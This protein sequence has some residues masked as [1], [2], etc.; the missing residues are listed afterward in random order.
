VLT[1]RNDAV[2][3]ELI[4]AEVEDLLAASR[5]QLKEARNGSWAIGAYDT[6]TLL[7]ALAVH[8]EAPR[9][10]VAEHLLEVVRD[11]SASR[12]WQLGALAGLRAY[13]RDGTLPEEVGT[14]LLSWPARAGVAQLG[15]ETKDDTRIL[16]AVL[17]VVRDRLGVSHVTLLAQLIRDPNAGVRIEAASALAGADTGRRITRSWALVSALFDPEDEVAIRT[18]LELASL[19]DPQLDEEALLVFTDRLSALLHEGTRNVRRAVVRV[20]RRH[21]AIF[22]SALRERAESDPSWLV[23]HEAETGA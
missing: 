2:L 7:G 1:W 17:D 4:A 10:D 12:D 22:G 13:S 23:R 8:E 11:P 18:L 15:D 9:A 19:E 5:R 6:R 3:P 20:V 14:A 21:S 16:A